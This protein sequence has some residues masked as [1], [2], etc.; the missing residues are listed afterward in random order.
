MPIGVP[1][2][3]PTG[4]PTGVYS[5]VPTGVPMSVYSGVPIGVPL[6]VP[7][8]DS[9]GWAKTR[10]R[11]DKREHTDRQGTP[12]KHTKTVDGA[13]IIPSEALQ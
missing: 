12:R 9:R 3:V 11:S 7:T 2:S 5:G 10:V 1:L 13:S 4:V 8:G 6:S